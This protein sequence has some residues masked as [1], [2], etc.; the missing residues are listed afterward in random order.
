M[1]NI[2]IKSKLLL[3]ERR[4]KVKIGEKIRQLRLERQLS[5]SQLGAIACIPQTTISDWEKSKSI[6]NVEE[7]KK[8]AN[9]LDVSLI[10]LLN[11]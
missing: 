6:P 10:D 8:I 3:M 11:D 1:S 2:E 7:V 5:Q 4:K 9:A